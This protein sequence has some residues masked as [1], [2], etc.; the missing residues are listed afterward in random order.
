MISESDINKDWFSPDDKPREACGLFGI[1]GHTEASKISYFG[2]YA[3]QHRGQE[4]AGIAVAVDNRIVDHKGMG[5]VSDVFDI[6]HFEQLNGLSAIGHVRYSTTG[7]SILSNAQPFVIHHRK[8]S[9]AVAHNGNLVN[10]HSL[11]N[12]LEEAGSIFQTT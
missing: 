1:F 12:E 5:L 9:Y 10:A 3:L 2:L 11:K 7:S 8:R 6:E 4:S